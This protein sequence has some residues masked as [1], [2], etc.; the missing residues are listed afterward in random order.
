VGEIDR[1]LKHTH[2]HD[3]ELAGILAELRALP[4]LTQRLT[5]ALQGMLMRDLQLQLPVADPLASPPAQA[6]VGAVAAGVA[7]ESAMGPLPQ[8]SFNPIRAGT[9][10]ITRLRLVDAF[11]RFKDYEAPNVFVSHALAPLSGSAPGTAFLP[12][13]ITQPA[14]LRFDWLSAADPDVVTNQDPATTPI[15]GWLLPLWL[16]HAVGLYRADG[17]A[18]GELGVSADRTRALWTPAPGGEW[19]PGTPIAQVLDGEQPDLAAVGQA[20][21]N[22]GDGSYLAPF[23]DGL[24]DALTFSLPAAFRE[25]AE[26]AVLAGQPLALARVTLGLELAGPAAVD[27]S[28]PSFAAQVLND[29]PPDDAGFANVSFPVILGA[30]TQ[31]DDTLVGYW[32]QSGAKTDYDTFYATTASPEHT[33][34]LTPTGASS[35]TTATMLLDPRGSV[36][37]TTGVLP[38]RTLRIPPALYGDAIRALVPTLAARP[39]LSG[40]R[41]APLCLALP[42]LDSGAWTWIAAAG[43]AW[44]SAPAADART[45]ATLD[46]TPQRIV[47]G[48]L[49]ND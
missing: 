13:R 38:V 2:D 26:S 42:K 34:P 33:V 18:L 1:Y 39:L 35:A 19:P 37:A 22:G 10:S 11:G 40:A 29:A 47:E 31:L 9:L 17:T 46:Y 41:D 23:F 44:A 20:L 21:Y 36:H 4:V 32:L 12:P 45:A 3:Q 24:R 27:E 15:A 25:S 49:R 7:P 14:R 28:W 48:W 8:N 16:D 5:G 43:E 6:F 30:L